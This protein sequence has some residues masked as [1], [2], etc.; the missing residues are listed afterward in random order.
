MAAFGLSQRHFSRSALHNWSSVTHD[1]RHHVSAFC[2][3]TPGKLPSFFIT[4]LFFARIPVFALL[5]PCFIALDLLKASD[6]TRSQSDR[7]TTTASSAHAPFPTHMLGGARPVDSVRICI[8][9]PVRIAQQF[10]T[11]DMS[12]VSSC[13]FMWAAVTEKKNTNPKTHHRSAFLARAAAALLTAV[14]L[15]HAFR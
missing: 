15:C 2:P 6:V 12:V 4:V 13:W 1:H 14:V 9:A 11:T 3:P 7:L 10:S 5:P 8:G